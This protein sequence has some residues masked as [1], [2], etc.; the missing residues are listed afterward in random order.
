LNKALGGSTNFNLQ[1]IRDHH[2]IGLS[3]IYC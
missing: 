1:I 2:H 3:G